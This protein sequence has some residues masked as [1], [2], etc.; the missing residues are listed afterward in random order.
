[1]ALDRAGGYLAGGY[2][3]WA[4]RRDE[5]LDRP[6]WHAFTTRQ[7][8]LAERGAG[9]LRLRGEYGIFASAAD[10]APA[11]L[12]GLAALVP[13]EGEL[14]VIQAEDH[15]D[16]PGVVMTPQPTICQM[17]AGELRA[18]PPPD[19]EVVDLGDGDAGAML[20]LATLTRPGP[21]FA[22]THQMGAFIGVREAGRLIA[23]AGERMRLPGLTEVSAVCTHPDHRG[24]GYAAAL[25]G[26]VAGRILARGETPFLHV[27]AHNTG[28]IAL[29]EHLGYRLRRQ[30]RM[31]LLS[32]A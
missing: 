20:E 1:M 3:R 27:Y 31:W 8:A 16:L 15:P 5:L 29:Y 32:R 14:A 13:A 21:F 12:A 2:G 26:I 10:A 23:M 19:F 24:R 7:A 6:I 25:M 17:V 28:A 18:L 4:V 9:A 30:M 22:R 11:S